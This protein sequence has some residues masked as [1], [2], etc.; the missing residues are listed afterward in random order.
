MSTYLDT[1]VAVWL[2]AGRVEEFSPAVLAE[3][4]SAELRI[5]PIV[6]LEIRLLQE[7]GRIDAGP[8][9]ILNVLRRDIGLTVCAIAFPDV[10]LAS[11][12][13]S[14]TRDPFDRLIVA[15]AKAGKGKLIS[16]DRK[17]RLAFNRALW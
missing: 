8:D 17:I 3:V 9:D 12:A 5:S 14:W 15:H 11:F 4:E 13:E 10:V 16:K 7:I 1:H 6:L 2:Y